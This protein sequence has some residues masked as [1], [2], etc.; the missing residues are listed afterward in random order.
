MDASQMIPIVPRPE[1]LVIFLRW[2]LFV[3]MQILYQAVQ[4]MYYTI[5]LT[6]FQGIQSSPIKYYV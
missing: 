5:F 1:I 4:C 6:Q 3:H 2:V